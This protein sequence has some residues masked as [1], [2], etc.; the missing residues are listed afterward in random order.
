[1]SNGY[2]NTEIK[3]YIA[4]ITFGHPKS[5]SLPG[6]ILI[7]LASQINEA[8]RNPQAKVIVLQSNGDKAFC[9]GASFDELLSIDNFDDGKRFFSGFASVINAI[10]KVP[11]FVIGR[12]QGKAVG[13]GVGLASACDYAIAHKSA[14]IKLSEFALGIGPFVVGP[15]VE[16]KIGK[17]AFAQFSTD[18]Q[19]Y[20]SLWAFSRGL[21]AKVT[22]T[23]EDLDTEVTKMAS[24]LAESSSEASVE[25]KKMYWEGT[26]NWDELLEKRAE[27]SGRLVLSEFTKNYIRQFKNS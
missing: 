9:A 21:Y 16:R 13:G 19:W 8:G 6:E 11:K 20:D 23:I 27:I 3:N 22:D 5:N 15:A 25:L 10:R 7:E 4:Y 12:I 2:V 14:S 24:F 17:A 26:E 18:I 1:M